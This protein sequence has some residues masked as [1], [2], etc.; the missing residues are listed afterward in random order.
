MSPLVAT[1]VLESMT[2]NEVR[3]LA[4]LP[5]VANGDKTKSQIAVETATITTQTPA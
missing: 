2:E 4:S 3:A 5:P 1:K